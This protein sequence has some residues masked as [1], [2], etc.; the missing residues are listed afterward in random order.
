MAGATINAL[1][2]SCTPAADLLPAVPAHFPGQSVALRAV[3]DFITAREDTVKRSVG[4]AF[5]PPANKMRGNPDCARRPAPLSRCMAR[6][7]LPAL[8]RATNHDRKLADIAKSEAS[9]C[10]AA[11]TNASTPAPDRRQRR[12][13]ANN[14]VGG[15]S[16]TTS[17]AVKPR[18]RSRQRLPAP[19]GAPQPRSKY[20]GVTFDASCGSWRARVNENVG[21]ERKR[22]V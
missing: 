19:P 4:V 2:L 12:Q 18:S 6:S 3:R 20:K 10:A 15:A 8:G 11:D 17:S 5:F 22:C 13:A 1:L 14:I 21:P 9:E 7:P 16:T